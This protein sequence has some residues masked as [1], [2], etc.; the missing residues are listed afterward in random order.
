MLSEKPACL[1]GM[2]HD[3]S[4]DGLVEERVSNILTQLS[5]VLLSSC[6]DN[7]L[8]WALLANKLLIQYHIVSLF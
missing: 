1:I 6:K 2:E 7:T 8:A 4:H 5:S 3:K